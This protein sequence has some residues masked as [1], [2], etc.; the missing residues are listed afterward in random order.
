MTFFFKIKM[1]FFGY[2]DPIKINNFQ[3][4]LNDVSAKNIAHSLSIQ[5]W[6]EYLKNLDC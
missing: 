4:D 3:G 1:I 6:N 2:F 5:L